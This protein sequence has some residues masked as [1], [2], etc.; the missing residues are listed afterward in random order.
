MVVGRVIDNYNNTKFKT[1]LKLVD[2]R[3]KYI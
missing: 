2:L 1:D 3:D